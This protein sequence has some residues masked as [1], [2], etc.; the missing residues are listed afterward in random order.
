MT[1]W[2]PRSNRALIAE[3]TQEFRHLKSDP[4]DCGWV[5]DKNLHVFLN[6]CLVHGNVA[7][8]YQQRVRKCCLPLSQL[9]FAFVRLRFYKSHPIKKKSVG[10]TKVVVA[11]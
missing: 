3:Y 5:E 1:A 9:F 7:V 2:K 4:N 6:C 10:N 11:T 8:Y